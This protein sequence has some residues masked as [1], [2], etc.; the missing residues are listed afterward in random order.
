MTLWME[1]QLNWTKSLHCLVLL[2]FGISKIIYGLIFFPS[3]WTLFVRYTPEQ[4]SHLKNTLVNH[5]YLAFGI[6]LP[7]EFST[8]I[9][10]LVYH[11]GEVFPLKFCSFLVAIS[12]G[13]QFSL[14]PIVTKSYWNEEIW[15]TSP[16]AI[17]SSFSFFNP[18]YCILF[19]A[20][21]FQFHSKFYFILPETERRSLEGIAYHYTNDVK[22][23]T[24]I[25]I[26]K[27]F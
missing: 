23:M 11:M 2:C 19:C 20:F 21:F 5:S 16:G 24:D 7:M 22:A 9:A 6:I 8:R 14:S 17:F 1:M 15:L 12:T 13:I 10:F 26:R 3:G 27:K 25:Q 18:I 4:Y